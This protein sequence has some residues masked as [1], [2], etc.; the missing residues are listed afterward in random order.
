VKI[1]PQWVVT[2]GNNNNNNKVFGNEEHM[3][4]SGPID[5]CNIRM[6]TNIKLRFSESNAA[7]T[8][9]LIWHLVTERTVHIQRLLEA[10]R[11]GTN[12]GT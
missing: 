7:V 2:A 9:A 11:E 8:V 10:L 1:Q 5:E 12:W 4:R 3:R 6:N